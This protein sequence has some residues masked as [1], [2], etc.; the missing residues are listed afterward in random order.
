MRRAR[1]ARARPRPA[2]DAAAPHAADRRV[3]HRAGRRGDRRSCAAATSTCS[4]SSPPRWCSSASSSLRMAGLVRQQERSV[5]RERT[6]SAAGASLVAATGRD[7]IYR[8]AARRPCAALR[9]APPLRA[10]AWSRTASSASSPPTA[11]SSSPGAT[12]AARRRDAP[13]SCWPRDPA[14]GVLL[15]DAMRDDLRLG[16]EHDHAHVLRPQPPRRRRAACS[17][18]AAR[19]RRRA[20][21]AARSSG[22]L[23]ALATQIS[24]ALESA[25]LTEEVHRRESEARFGSLVQHASDLITVLDADATRSSTRARRSSA[26]SATRPADVIGTRFDRAPRPR[27]EEPPAAACWPTAAPYAGE[28]DRGPRVLAAP[29]RRRRCASS[30]SCTRT[31]SRT[32]TS[33]ASSSTAATSA[34]ARPSRSSSPTRPSTTRSPASPTARCSSSACATPSPAAGASSTASRVIFLDLDD[35]K[36]IN[37]SLGHAAGDEVLR[38]VGRAPGHEHPRHRHR[39]ALRRRRVRDPARGRRQ[40][41]GG[42]R[43]RRAHPRVAPGAAARWT[44][45]E[46]VVRASLGISVV[47]G[48]SPRRRRRAHPQRRR[49]DVHRQARRQGRLPPVRAGDARGRRSRAWSCAPTCSAPW[50]PTSSSCTTSRWSGS[51]TA[52]SPGVEA[53][54]RW[55][56]PERG[57][58]G[59]DEFMP[60][61]EEMGLIVPIGR[62]VLREGCRQAKAH[63][64]AGAARRAAD[65]E[66]QPLGQAAAA[67]RHRRRRPRGARATPAWRPRRSRS[68][69][70]RR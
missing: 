17:S 34:S 70:P 4:S 40:R 6:L 68:R 54:L 29:P 67:L 11:A 24:L 65:D 33:A 69:S 61:A 3:A 16:P 31:C 20:R 63:P 1:A 26:S 41:A 48:E 55:R 7:E 57:L 44:S 5:A 43:H 60:L 10:C 27:R 12:L 25:A 13:P 14:A 2:P 38:E 8:A 51:R 22:A 23:R 66:R 53:L 15:V 30:R 19:R 62:W 18:S 58:V 50:S 59:P 37:D 45:K 35:F 52:P 21:R 39:R 32:S 9:R 36:T 49:R 47:E 28:R 46:I 42:G 64:G 56:H